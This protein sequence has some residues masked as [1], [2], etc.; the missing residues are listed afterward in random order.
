MAVLPPVPGVARLK[1]NNRLNANDWSFGLH[2]LKSVADLWEAHE[3][4]DLLTIAAGAITSNLIPQLGASTTSVNVQ[5]TDLTSAMGIQAE[6]ATGG[7]G[8]GPGTKPLPVNVTLHASFPSPLRYRGGRPGMNIAGLDQ[9]DLLPSSSSMW[10]V[11]T[12]AAW[13]STIDDLVG[14]FATSLPSSSATIIPVW[15]SYFSGHAVRPVPL[16]F[17]ISFDFV[18]IQQRI[19]SRRRR[20]GK[21][22]P[23]E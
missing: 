19:C 5:A 7:S 20:L 22:V 10:S 16:T 15:V 14:A 18:E 8:T 13:E 21:G 2:V 9:D 4:S 12:T 1:F 23:G 3:I 6:L 11:P 17:P